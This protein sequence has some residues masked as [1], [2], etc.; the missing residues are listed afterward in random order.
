MPENQPYTK[1]VEYTVRDRCLH[2]NLDRVRALCDAVA[3][4]ALPNFRYVVWRREDGLSFV[5]VAT[6]EAPGAQAAF[7]ALP[8][9]AAFS[10]GLAARCQAPPRFTL[11]AAVGAW[12]VSTT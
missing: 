1:L 12:R 10:R 2:D 7:H 5:H 11:L 8:E 6:V 3:R 4:E 9:F